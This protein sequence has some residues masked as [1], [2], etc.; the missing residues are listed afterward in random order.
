M[1]RRPWNTRF[2]TG[3]AGAASAIVMLFHNL[4]RALGGQVTGFLFWA[5]PVAAGLLVAAL[6]ASIA[7]LRNRL[8]R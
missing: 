4:S 6:A 7:A 5:E 1:T 2:I 8:A 3:A